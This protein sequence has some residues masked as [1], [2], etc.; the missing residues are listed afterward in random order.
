MVAIQG[1]GMCHCQGVSCM[2]QSEWLVCNYSSGTEVTP[3]TWKR[4]RVVIE[5]DE[6]ILRIKIRKDLQNRMD[7][8]YSSCITV[9]ENAKNIDIHLP[10]SLFFFSLSY[11]HQR[12]ICKSFGD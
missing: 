11:C 1:P 4:E 8:L 9:R 12:A 6:M 2:D 10:L 5:K 7:S 3:G